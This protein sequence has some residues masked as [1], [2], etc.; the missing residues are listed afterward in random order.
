MI[1]GGLNGARIL[2][3]ALSKKEFFLR[4]PEFHFP[5]FALSPQESEGLPD[6]LT[7]AL[8]FLVKHDVPRVRTVSSDIF[9]IVGETISALLEVESQNKRF[10]GR[11]KNPDYFDPLLRKILFSGFFAEKDLFKTLFFAFLLFGGKSFLNR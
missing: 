3:Q 4:P 10:R 9:F 7:R 5:S 6:K 1:S 2:L 11:T 8:Y